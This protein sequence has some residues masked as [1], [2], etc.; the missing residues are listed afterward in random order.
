MDVEN[1]NTLTNKKILL[2][3]T[4][5]IAAY[6]SAVLCRE[7]IKSG[8]EVRIIMTPSATSFISALTLSTLS[9]HEVFIDI[10]DQKSWNNH[11]ELALWADLFLVAPCT[12]TSL[13]KMA[14][15]IADNMLV[16]TYL[17][18]KCPVMIA[19]AMDLDMWK[20]PS[21]NN[22]IEL[23][24]SYGHDIIPVGNGFLASGLHGEGR[25]AEPHEIVHYVQKYF[26][27]KWTLKDKKIL[28]TAGPTYEHIDP[29]RFIGNHSS[30]KM[31]LSLALTCAER[32]AKVTLILGPSH[33]NIEH[34]NIKVIPVTTGEEMYEATHEHYTTSDVTI[35]AAA[36]ADYRPQVIETQK[37]KKTDSNL[38]I[39]LVKNK[40]IAYE[41]GLIKRKSQ[42]NIGFALETNDEIFN[43]QTKIHKKNFDFIVLNSLKDDGAG[44]KVDTN[45]IKIINNMDEILDFGLKPKNQVASDIIDYLEDI[46]KINN[47]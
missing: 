12:A 37:I 31:G 39:E 3:I 10:N 40:D 5:S 24:I 20:H 28:I 17:S 14:H 42:I 25:M 18:A 30:G 8:F 11:V 1:G 6:K 45:K 34:S 36:V 27:Q 32:G 29:V 19:P 21:T 38:I 47:A 44:F 41:M 4:G 2:G 7:L 35:F 22:N 26:N 13:S 15:G 43:A 9:G 33:L 16:A 23:L 46:L